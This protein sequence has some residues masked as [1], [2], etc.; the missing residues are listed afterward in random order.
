MWAVVLVVLLA[1]LADDARPN[2]CTNSGSVTDL[3]LSH[4]VT[5]WITISLIS[6]EHAMQNLTSFDLSDNFVSY[7][8]WYRDLTPALLYV[9]ILKL[10]ENIVSSHVR[11]YS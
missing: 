5:D 4:L 6:D 9:R 11:T 8:E 2:L 7:T 10:A 1:E 3:E